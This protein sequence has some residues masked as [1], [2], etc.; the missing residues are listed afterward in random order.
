MN[1]ELLLAAL[2]FV[3]VVAALGW[4]AMIHA[5]ISD[6]V[7]ELRIHDGEINDLRLDAHKLA[8]EQT[9][10]ALFVGK[11]LRGISNTVGQNHQLVNK[12]GEE[13][14]SISHHCGRLEQLARRQGWRWING[15]DARWE[16][17]DALAQ[18]KHAQSET[19][20]RHG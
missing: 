3:G 16:H 4:I 7:Q 19:E 13:M 10:N 11:Q 17:V 6:S 15:S 2:A 5:R 20:A 18:A 9:D 14:V 1:A 12:L 8:N